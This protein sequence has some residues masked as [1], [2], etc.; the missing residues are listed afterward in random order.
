MNLKQKRKEIMHSCLESESCD[1][2]DLHKAI[3]EI[4]RKLMYK[5]YVKYGRNYLGN[6]FKSASDFSNKM[7]NDE[8]YDVLRGDFEIR[9][10][11]S[12]SGRPVLVNFE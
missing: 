7:L 10:D 6:Q 5:A 3:T 11:Y 12:K 8:A 9:S 1:S 4:D 2:Y